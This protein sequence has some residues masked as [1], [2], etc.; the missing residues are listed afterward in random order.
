VF[1]N[2]TPPDSDQQAPAP[3]VAPEL[4]PLSHLELDLNPPTDG[5]A[6]YLAARD[7]GIVLDDLGRASVA[8]DAARGLFSERREAE[9][10]AREHAAAAERQAIE[11]DQQWR[12]QLPHGLPWFEVPEGLHPATAMLTVARDEDPRRRSLAEDLDRPDGGVTFHSI[13]GEES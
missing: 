9:A 3:N 11:A 7:I 4:I 2:S 12:A 8:R 5:W 13:Q 6:A 10:K 1:R